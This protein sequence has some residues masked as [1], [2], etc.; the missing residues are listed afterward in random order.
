M[1]LQTKQ[2][3]RLSDGKEAAYDE[4]QPLEHK[5]SELVFVWCHIL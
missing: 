1:K 5:L 2:R 4:P 3:G